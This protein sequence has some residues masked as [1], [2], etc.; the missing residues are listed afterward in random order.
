[1]EKEFKDAIITIDCDVVKIIDYM[2][3]NINTTK[4]IPVMEQLTSLAPI[5]WGHYAR[6][7]IRP[8]SI[9]A[10]DVSTPRIKAD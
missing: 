4:L 10:I 1:M 7:N 8:I 3:Y 6:E 9:D 2:K 5:L